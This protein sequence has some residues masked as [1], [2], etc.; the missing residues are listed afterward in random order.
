[1]ILLGQLTVASQANTAQLEEIVITA[2]LMEADINHLSVT[3]VTERDV[4]ARGAAHFEDLL[5]LVPNLSASAGASRQRFFQ[6]RGIGER[7]QFVEPIN[8]SVILLQDG[9]DISG[10]RQRTDHLRYLA[11]G[12]IQRPPRRNYGCGCIGGPHQHRNT[13]PHK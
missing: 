12:N 11:S 1:M 9:I 2:A 6:I 7:S 10:P 4:S 13:D 3:S 5:T 8:P